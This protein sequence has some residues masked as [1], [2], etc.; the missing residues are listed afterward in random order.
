MHVRRRLLAAATPLMLLTSCSA[1]VPVTA[2]QDA[3]DPT[4]A[5]IVLATPTRLGQDL[6][7]VATTAQ[8]TRAWGTVAEPV[9][10]RC[11]VPVPGPTTD[12]CVT[13]ET[14][15]G[16]SIDWLVVPDDAAATASTGWTFTTFGR[17][18]AVQVYVP[19]AVAGTR[20]TSFLDELGPAMALAE[21]T[22]SCS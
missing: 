7:E 15:G 14:S 20:S 1:A 16:P 3:T 13:V 9:V 8:A 18:P 12:R 4:C 19:A 22:G 10:L 17:R 5:R 6:D 21:Q 11:G 2:A